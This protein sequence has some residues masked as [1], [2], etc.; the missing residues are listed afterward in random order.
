MYGYTH[1]HSIPDLAAKT[2]TSGNARHIPTNLQYAVNSDDRL[3]RLD[4][5][6]RITGREFHEHLNME[7]QNWKPPPKTILV[8]LDMSEQSFFSLKYVVQNLAMDGDT[9]EVLRVIQDQP[10]KSDANYCKL[11]S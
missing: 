7:N 5:S 6:C 3:I 10:S 4:K 1:P 8:A 9:V 2:I 11:I